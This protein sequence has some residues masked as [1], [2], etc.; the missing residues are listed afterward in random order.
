MNMPELGLDLAS[1]RVRKRS[2]YGYHLD[3][4]LRW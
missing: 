2:D 3:F 4:R 1:K